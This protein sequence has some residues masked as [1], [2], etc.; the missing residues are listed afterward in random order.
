MAIFKSLL[1]ECE[2]SAFNLG[3]CND[4]Y[5]TVQIIINEKNIEILPPP[6]CPGRTQSCAGWQP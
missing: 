1:K 3:L 6:P 5:G 4:V 2:K